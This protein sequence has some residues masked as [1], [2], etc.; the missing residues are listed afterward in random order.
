MWHFND[1]LQYQKHLPNKFMQD[2]FLVVLILVNFLPRSSLLL[3]KPNEKSLLSFLGDSN[4]Y[5]EQ[6]I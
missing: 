6:L 1:A 2:I 3:W 5:N 4:Y